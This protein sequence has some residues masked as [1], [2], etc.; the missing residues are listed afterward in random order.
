MAGY[1]IR[2]IIFFFPTVF[3]VVTFVFFFIH[4]I[5]GDPVEIMLGETALAADKV[6]L[7]KDLGLD[8]P[9][10]KQY[11]R[12]LGGVLKG[13]LGQSYFYGRP[14]FPIIG[15]KV[16]ATMELAVAGMVI[17]I[18]IAIPL[19]ILSAIRHHSLW[20]TGAM[21][22][23]LIG[24][25]VPNFWM[26]PL[27]IILFSIKLGWLPVCG[28]DDWNSL[29]LPAVTLGTAMAAILSRMTRSSMLD[30]LGEEYLRCARAKGLPPS[31][32][33]LKHALRNA[34]GPII[35][36]IG[37]QFGA[38]LS[39]AII[40]E[41]VFAWPG[42]GTLLIRSVESRDYPVVQGCV[43]FIAIGYVLINLLTDLAYGAADPRI[44][45]TGER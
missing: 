7:R 18:F 12:F 20:D 37:L 19:G 14:V 32:I 15:E 6:K 40:T 41:T 31:K 26:G 9:I 10:H 21:F 5:P 27:L 30:V 22:L 28:R 23:S 42:I 39:G 43:I 4:M 25:S 29:I 36:V 2:R 8:L 1:V 38:L 34:L 16:A 44:R 33:I 45:Y 11:I 17:A 13:D 24:I 35:T 3:G